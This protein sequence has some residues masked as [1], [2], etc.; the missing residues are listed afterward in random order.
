MENPGEI[1]KEHRKGEAGT[2]LVEVLV[3]LLIFL[4]L[5]MG[6]LQMFAVAFLVNKG[7]QARTEMTYKTQQ[8]VE[9]LRY[10]NAIYKKGGAAALTGATGADTQTPLWWPLGTWTEKELY[11]GTA[12]PSQTAL[13]N[14][15]WG[16]R[17][18]NVVEMLNPP[19][20]LTLEVTDGNLSGAPGYWILTVTCKPNPN[21]TAGTAPQTRGSIQRKKVIEYVANLPK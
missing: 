11:T 8:V 14:S 20:A 15:F 3:A 5:M 1:L 19:Y 17:K 21:A 6:V 2:S 12:F 10:L 16:P 13:D 4:L 7:S 18:A 9:N